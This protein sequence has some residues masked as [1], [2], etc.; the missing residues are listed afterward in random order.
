MNVE[1]TAAAYCVAVGSKVM[2][3]HSTFRIAKNVPFL[4]REAVVSA[5]PRLGYVVNL[6]VI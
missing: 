3:V 6:F 5:S 4:T 1:A 2:K